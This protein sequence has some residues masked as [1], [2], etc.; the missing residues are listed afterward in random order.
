VT[1]GVPDFEI[2]DETYKGYYV[3]DGVTPL[4]TTAEPSSTPTIGWAKN[5]ANPALLYF[6][7]VMMHLHSGIQVSGSS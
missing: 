4:L 7:A 3:E 1:K 5:T 6:R 2:F